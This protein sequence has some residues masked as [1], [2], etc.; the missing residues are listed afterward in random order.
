MTSHAGTRGRRAL[1]TSVRGGIA[2]VA[3]VGSTLSSAGRP[4]RQP[5]EAGSARLT[6]PF[7]ANATR[8]TD[9]DFAAAEC[10]LV[11]KDGLMVCRFRQVFLTATSIDAT[12]CAITTNGYQQTFR[13]VTETR[14]VSESNPTGD[15][16][17][18][19]TT[20][21]EDGGS[22]RWSMTNRT[23]ATQNTDRAECRAAV[24]EPEVYDWRGVKRK[25]PCTWIQP[26]GIER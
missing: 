7:L 2:L 19:E 17:L 14:W 10:D 5:A 20:T 24:P 18:V 1:F 6:I 4:Q 22:T 11:P 26:G 8:P 23:T 25:L 13:R 9:L 12:S 16:G 15:C 21:L 3:I